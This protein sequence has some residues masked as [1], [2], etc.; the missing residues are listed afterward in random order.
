MTTELLIRKFHDLARCEPDTAL[1]AESLIGFF[2]TFRPDGLEIAD[3]YSELDVGDAL[4][5]R[6]DLLYAACGD[7]RRPDGGRD[8]YFVVRTPPPLDPDLAAQ[9]GRS[10][11]GGLRELA[12]S[13]GDSLVADILEPTPTIRVLEGIPPK[14]PKLQS[15]RSQ[16]LCAILE[17]SPRLVERIDAGPYP[18]VLRPAYYFTA[19]DSMLRD[20]LMWP[21]YADACGLEDPLRPY[22]ELWRHGVKYR[23]FGETQVDLYLPRHHHG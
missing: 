13:L 20:Y 5:Q 2:Q 9:L 14:H 6:L 19:C 4:H 16:L 22:F 3:L 7:G 17:E 11:I 15:E 12:F 21:L 23:I 18:E 8:A 10:W 1:D